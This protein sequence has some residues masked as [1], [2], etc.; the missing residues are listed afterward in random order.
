MRWGGTS[1]TDTRRG[2]PW[3]D[4][5]CYI[6]WGTSQKVLARLCRRGAL[7][8]ADIRVQDWKF[9]GATLQE[10]QVPVGSKSGSPGD[11]CPKIVKDCGLAGVGFRPPH[12]LT[13]SSRFVTIDVRC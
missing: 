10:A 11:F 12:C 13:R 9:R 7:P 5:L 8:P 3:S 2:T 4:G 6:L 1:H